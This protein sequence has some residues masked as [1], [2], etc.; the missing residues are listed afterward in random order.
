MILGISLAF[1]AYKSSPHVLPSWRVTIIHSL[2]KPVLQCPD[3]LD[4][5]VGGN[6]RVRNMKGF[7]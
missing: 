5:V 2:A 1:T 6:P 4:G 3:I 7:A